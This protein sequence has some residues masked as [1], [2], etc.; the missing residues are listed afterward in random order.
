MVLDGLLLADKGPAVT[1]FQVVAHL[2]RVLR[3]PKVG[4]GGTLDPMATGLL[5]ILLGEATKL[6]GHLQGQDKEYLA[7]IRLGVAT[8]TLDATGTVTGKRPVP[9]LTADNVRA[10]LARF[11]GDIDQVP[12]MYSALHVGGRRLHE[13]ARAGIAVE[14][15]PRRVRVHAFELIECAPPRLRV[16]V[17]CG[18]GTYIRSLA[19]DVGEALGCGGHVEALARTRVGPLRLEDAVPWAVIQEGNVAALA[20]GMLPADRAVAHLPAIRL[21]PEAGRRLAHGQRVPVTELVAVDSPAAPV[22]CRVYAGT[23][24]LGIGEL[25]PEGLRPLRL[26]H[27]DRSRPR[28]VSP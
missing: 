7:T 26:V 9:P 6:T 14:R 21:S 20:A 3:V 15:A 28:P 17:E 5:P 24:F 11:V 23:S 8:D 2:R 13:L 22:P 27:A 19:A 10:V 25:S 16:R 12:P 18:S 1:S 4:H